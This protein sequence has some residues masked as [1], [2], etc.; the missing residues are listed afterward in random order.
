MLGTCASTQ[1]HSPD[2]VAMLWGY[3]STLEYSLYNTVMLVVSVSSQEHSP[4]SATILRV[5]VSTE[6]LSPDNAAMLGAFLS[7]QGVCYWF[8]DLILLN[9]NGV[10]FFLKDFN[11]HPSII[12][13]KTFCVAVEHI[14]EEARF[15][16]L[17]F[18]TSYPLFQDWKDWF[19]NRKPSF[20][21]IQ[22]NFIIHGKDSRCRIDYKIKST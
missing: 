17:V 4:E 20:I 16:A 6:E 18:G 19:Y 2:S 22:L 1:E 10:I 8:T 9:I 13:V 15:T 14:T 5:C 7:T 12:T 3:V 21:W 11:L